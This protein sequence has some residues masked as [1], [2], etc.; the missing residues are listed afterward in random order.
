MNE[1]VKLTEVTQ[2][3]ET[4]EVSEYFESDAW[5]FSACGD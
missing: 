5:A 3:V 1:N 2:E 4:E